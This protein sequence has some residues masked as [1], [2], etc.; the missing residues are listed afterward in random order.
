GCLEPFLACQRSSGRC[1]A[2][3]L[4]ITTVPMGASAAGD[5][6]PLRKGSET[7]WR[8]DGDGLHNGG[9]TRNNDGCAGAMQGS[10]PGE[11]MDSARD[12]LRSIGRHGVRAH[13]GACCC[14]RAN[15]WSCPTERSTG[16]DPPRF[17]TNA[18]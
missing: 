13:G 3:S 17:A 16:G 1:M 11:N 14:P 4:I 12:V 2:A 6:T 5:Q 8:T 18:A 10:Q 7:L 9:E 15:A